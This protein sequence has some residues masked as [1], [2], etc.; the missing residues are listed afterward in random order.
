MF[1]DDD[2]SGE[3]DFDPDEDPLLDS[4]I[5]VVVTAQTA[6]VSLLQ[7]RLRVGYTRA[8]RLIDM[9]ERRGIIS[10][11]EGSK[12]R[13]VLRRRARPRAASAPRLTR[14]R[15][16]LDNRFASRA[17][18]GLASPCV[19]HRDVVKT[20]KQEGNVK[21]SVESIAGGRRRARALARDRRGARSA[22]SSAPKADATT[23]ALISDI[24]KFND[25]GFNQNQ[26]AGLN[27]AKTKLGIDPLPKQS[28]SVSDYIPN[29]TSAVRQNADLVIAAGFLLADATATMAKKFPDTHFAITDYTVQ[30]APFADK[31]GKPLY[32]NVEGLT[33]AANEGGCL[34]GVL[35][36]KWRRRPARRR[37]APSA[38]SRSRRSTSG[39]PATSSARRW[40][41]RAR[42]C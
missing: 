26:L 37:S 2:D 9:L 21:R 16:G 39:S 27:K 15:G 7:R 14:D 23:V 24:G 28:N 1:A 6:S 34:V 12:P 36:A 4:A 11:Y 10:A 3:G 29:L 13:R 38:A 25:R 20:L 18:K 22:G 33:Y 35:A 32:K 40:P 30:A 31:K 8:G 42:R 19:T 5:E 41:C 17:S